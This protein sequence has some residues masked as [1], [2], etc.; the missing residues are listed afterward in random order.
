MPAPWVSLVSN[1][2][3]F[4]TAEWFRDCQHRAAVWTARWS[5]QWSKEV[6]LTTSRSFPRS[7]GA[8]QRSRSRSAAGHRRGTWCG[9]PGSCSVR[10]RRPPDRS[11]WAVADPHH[12][13]EPV[14]H[15]LCPDPRRVPARGLAG[16]SQRLPGGGVARAGA[17]L[18]AG[19]KLAH[20]CRGP[21]RGLTAERA[22]ADDPEALARA[23]TLLLDGALAEG[24]LA[25]EPSA[26]Q[27]AKDAAAALVELHC[28]A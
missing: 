7:T 9:P 12:R 4:A 1:C 10:R 15:R 19:A 28:R 17:G 21:C 20:R 14:R 8:S 27:A 5:A 16:R 25:A 3:A 6:M 23:L 18:A 22:G 24:V 11:R 26:A 2:R 13:K